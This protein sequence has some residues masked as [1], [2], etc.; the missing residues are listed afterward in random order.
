[1]LLI[2]RKSGGR[3]YLEPAEKDDIPVFKHC[4]G[5]FSAITQS[6]YN[7]FVE[8]AFLHGIQSVAITTHK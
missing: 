4:S 5:G 8:V 6:G 3:W 2:K 7:D 1:M